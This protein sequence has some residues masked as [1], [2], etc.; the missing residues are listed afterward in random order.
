MLS[1]DG[2]DSVT[3]HRLFQEGKLGA[4][5]FARFFR[6]GQV[7][8]GMQPINPS[9]TAVNHIAL[10]TG[11]AA[12]E[13]GIVGNDFLLPGAPLGRTVSGFAADI[14]TE[15]LWEAARRQSLRVAVS[16]WPGADGRDERRRGDWGM[17][18]SGKP[19]RKAEIVEIPRGSWRGG[20][21]PRAG[22]WSLVPCRDGG[23]PGCYAKILGNAS[24]PSRVRVYLGGEYALHAYPEAFESK[25]HRDGLIWPGPP[26][27]KLLVESW[28]GGSAGIDLETWLE[29]DER[30]ATFFMDA[31]LAVARFG[32]WDLLMGYTPVLD[33]A[34]H[35]L[36]L[37]DPRQPGYSPERRDEL[38]RARTRIWQAVDRDLAR[39]VAAVDLRTTTVLV[40][41]DHG[42][43]PTHTVLDPALLLRDWGFLSF[44]GHGKP[45]A[46]ASLAD[47]VGEGGLC[48]V[49]VRSGLPGRESLLENL[50]SR[51]LSWKVGDEAPIAR[52]FTRAEAA[53]IGLDHANSGDLILLARSGYHFR[54]PSDPVGAAPASPSKAVYGKHG[55]LSTEPA[56][57]A[58]YMALGRGV[59]PGSRGVVKNTDVAAEVAAWLGMEPPRRR[60]TAP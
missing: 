54:D 48:Y 44:D 27:G 9:I 5:G 47:A 39:L 37:T 31:L 22:E 58:V 24:G 59:T 13:T 32:E 38:D 53:E 25:L 14:G 3:L 15:T 17:T 4:G 60:V 43:A 33:E 42:M 30:F 19:E 1:L 46:G 29:Q 21:G 35:Q 36:L 41:S 16:A 45:D 2:A 6:D 52:V 28:R 50:R 7:A 49:Y 40:V 12:V 34:G 51:F 20:L 55:Y 56:M 8:E 23:P 26:D 57:Q 18:Y 10:A 11:H